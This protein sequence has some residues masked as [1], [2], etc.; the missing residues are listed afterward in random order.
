MRIE[1][2]T[3]QRSDRRREER[4][5]TQLIATMAAATAVSRS[6]GS[7]VIVT[8]AVVVVRHSATAGLTSLGYSG[9]I[10]LISL[11]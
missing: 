5:P 11:Q 9:P 6:L 8:A 7:L 4:H 3:H 10:L 1:K 2:H